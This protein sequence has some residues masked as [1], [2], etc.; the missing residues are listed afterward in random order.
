MKTL[1][2]QMR[3]TVVDAAVE[4]WTRDYN[5]GTL[6]KLPWIKGPPSINS[7]RDY[8][9]FFLRVTDFMECNWHGGFV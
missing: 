4:D 7:N 2:L 5:I 8:L 6:L 9:L 3:T 1:M